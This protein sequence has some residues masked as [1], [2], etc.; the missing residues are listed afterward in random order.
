MFLALA[1]ALALF[2]LIAGA[3]KYKGISKVCGVAALLAFV[4]WLASGPGFALLKW[5]DNPSVDVPE[6]IPI[7]GGK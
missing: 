7:P 6:N 1:I 5:L 4:A 2:S 3:A